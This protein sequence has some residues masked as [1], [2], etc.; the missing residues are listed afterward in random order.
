[1]THFKKNKVQ[2]YLSRMRERGFAAP[3]VLAGTHL[4]EEGVGGGNYFASPEAYRRIILNMLT[5]TGD[6]HLGMA[7]G[8]EF[9]ISDLGVL[10][11]AALSSATLAQARQVIQRYYTLNEYIVLPSNYIQHGGWYSELRESFPLG[12]LM[13]FAVEEFVSRSVNLSRSLT[14]RSFP[15]LELHLSYPE[16]DQSAVYKEWFDCPVRY[17]QPKNLIKFDIE[18]LNDPISMADDDVFAICDQQCRELIREQER[19]DQL[20]DKIQ[21]I[22]LNMP[23]KFPTMEEMAERLCIS[24]RTLRR[25]LSNEGIAYQEILD[26]TRESLAMQYLAHTSLTPKEIGFLLG[27]SNVSNFRRAFRTWT[28]KKV[29]DYRE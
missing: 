4:T 11:Y 3:E 27:Y 22:L 8:R 19:S 28:G 7:M 23:G 13:P 6:K 16:P 26:S 21:R 1:M 25:Q 17:N 15:I 29:S 2:F 12:T 14:D 20:P 10:G 18:R 5:L 24:A 9:K